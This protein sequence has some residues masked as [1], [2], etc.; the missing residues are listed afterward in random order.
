MSKLVDVRYSRRLIAVVVPTG[1]FGLAFLLPVAKLMNA[2][3]WLGSVS[4]YEA[5]QM[6]YRAWFSPEMEDWNLTRAL[7]AGAWLANFAIPA[8]VLSLAFGVRRIAIIAGVTGVLLTL[9]PLPDFW[10][11]ILHQPGYWCWTGSAVAAILAS[12]LLHKSPQSSAAEDYLPL[13]KAEQLARRSI[14]H[15]SESRHSS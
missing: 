2:K 3:P 8:A 5:F 9:C 14:V 6:G 15:H 4:G 10:E 12:L 13:S 7:I 11:L 1:I